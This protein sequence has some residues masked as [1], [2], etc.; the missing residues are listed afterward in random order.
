[1][2]SGGAF[3]RAGENF[4]AT[5]SAVNAACAANLSTYTR[6]ID[7]P[8]AC[9][10]RNF[11]KEA[12][13]ESVMLSRALASGLVELTNN[14]ALGNPAAF[15]SFNNGSASNTT[16]NWSEAGI[17]TLTPSVGDGNYLGA[18]ETVGITSGKVGRFYPDHFAITASPPSAGCGTFTYFGQ[19][20][21]T[22]PFT[23]TA[24]NTANVTTRNYTGSFAKLGLTTWSHFAFTT[25]SALPAGSTLSGSATAPSGTW[26]QGV[27]TVSAKHQISRPSALAGETSVTLFA[28]P[29]D[30]DGVT[31]INASAV[32]TASTPLRYGRL[33]LGNAYGS[34]R[35]DLSLPYETQYWNGLAFIRNTLDGCT[36]LSTANVGIGN[37]Q[38]S[39]N[40]SSLPTGS[41]TMGA[42]SSGVGTVRLKAPNAAGSVDVVL[43]LD[44]ALAMCPAWAPTYPAG[45]ARSATYLRGKWCGAAFDRD[46]VARATFGIYSSNTNRQIY[47]REGF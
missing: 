23:L 21:F 5:V 46:A 33:W 41:I 16:L 18:G 14:P 22:T 28:R 1:D 31:M 40:G 43:R 19:D 9:L 4:S 26:N 35:N 20:G 32:Q 12:P 6:L 47:L 13:P 39:V 24:Q 25:S 10:T 11:G 15:G 44:P 42:F 7:I 17:I 45:T 38:G 30:S 3:V 34:E 27:A 2:A 37:Y 36:A 29:T 8:S